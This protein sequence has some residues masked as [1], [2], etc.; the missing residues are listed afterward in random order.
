[1]KIKVLGTGCAKCRKLYAAAE[2]AI[3]ASGVKVELEKIEQQDEIMKYGVVM[4][5]AL[6]LDEEVK[7]AGRIPPS[8]EIALWI[9]NADGKAPK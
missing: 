8:T 4:T 7:A 2:K 6:V 9:K 3:A 1:M 5:P